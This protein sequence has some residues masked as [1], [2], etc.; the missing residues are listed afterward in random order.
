MGTCKG[1]QNGTGAMIPSERE[2]AGE[3]VGKQGIKIRAI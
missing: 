2:H 1:K 3:D